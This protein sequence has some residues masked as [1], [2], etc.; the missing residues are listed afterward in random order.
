MLKNILFILLVSNLPVCLAEE[1]SEEEAV[2]IAIQEAINAEV[3]EAEQVAL[4]AATEAEKANSQAQ[5]ATAQLQSVTEDITDVINL[6][7][8]IEKDKVSQHSELQKAANDVLT[9]ENAEDEAVQA[10]IALKIKKEGKANFWE[11][12]LLAFKRIQAKSTD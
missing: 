11:N 7:H 9:T 10:Y 8:E 1:A 3:D 6:F 4:L 2:R 12:A 5:I